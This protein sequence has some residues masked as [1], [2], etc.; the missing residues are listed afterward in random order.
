MN[1]PP[2]DKQIKALE[3]IA[4]AVDFGYRDVVIAAPTGVGKTGIGVTVC[5]WAAS[6]AAERLSGNPGGYYL[7][8]QKI[9]QRQITTDFDN[10]KF[11][12]E[13]ATIKAAVDYPC[14]KFKNCGAGRRAK[15]RC[16]CETCPYVLAKERFIASRTAITNYPY[17]FAEHKYVGKLP[18]RRA[19][20]CD[21]AHAVERQ[22]I[23][24]N[25]L[26][27]DQETIARWLGSMVAMP[28]LR[29]L[30]QFIDWI[31]SD[32][33]PGI[34]E[35]MEAIKQ[36]AE[37][38]LS[39][40]EAKDMVDL[41]Q[42]MCKVNRAVKLVESDPTDW[43]YWDEVLRDGSY[44]CTARPLDAAPFVPDLVNSMGSL[45]VY[46]SAFPGEK[47][48]FCRS[49]GLKHE[50]VAWI[51]LDSPFPVE[52]RRIF[53]TGVGSMS[54]RNVDESFS[55]FVKVAIKILERHKGE[56]GLIHCNSYQLGERI[57]K[58]LADSD[59]ADRLL[60]PKTADE[61]EAAFAK[62]GSSTSTD[63]VLVSPSMTEGFDFAD[64]LARWQIIAKVP[65]PSL[66]DA[67]V[68]AKKERDDEWYALQT[69]MT[70]VQA[71]GRIC[72]SETDR[73]ITY[74]LDGDFV[75]LFDQHSNLF[76]PWW[77]DAVVWP[78]A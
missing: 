24:F 3:F 65:Y 60:F 9:L 6:Q 35:K 37:G 64:D 40:N 18:Q 50:R 62:H 76:P 17:L 29:R 5:E 10:G 49:L 53:V 68:V 41:D 12:G 69:I 22:L 78:R 8:V 16:E 46:M 32:Y 66:G 28:K 72:R 54:K 33:L 1:S 73:G 67:Q 19:I 51:N 7:T 14:A 58:A 52:N 39:D 70:I 42:H 15:K 61:R 57:V 2:R 38:A 45:R 23:R 27:L 36:L 75:R 63:T 47:K 21:E 34:N 44:S 74:I 55:V 26:T 30:D 71:A 31:K 56:R 13:G 48:V 59:H 43:V 4:K 11:N 77:T 20:I 25:D